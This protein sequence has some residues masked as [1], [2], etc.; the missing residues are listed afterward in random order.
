MP[1]RWTPAADFND[2]R[3]FSGSAAARAGN[4]TST[5]QLAAQGGMGGVVLLCFFWRDASS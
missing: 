2:R 4:L 5:R 3:D 1:H